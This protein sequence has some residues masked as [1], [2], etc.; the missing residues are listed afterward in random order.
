MVF[1]RCSLVD[2]NAIDQPEERTIHRPNTPASAEKTALGLVACAPCTA[3]SVYANAPLYTSLLPFFE[4]RV[5]G[6]ENQEGGACLSQNG[7]SMPTHLP[8]DV[9]GLLVLPYM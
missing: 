1:V 9:L 7:T 6:R 3:W 8:I 4:N 5:G 2:T